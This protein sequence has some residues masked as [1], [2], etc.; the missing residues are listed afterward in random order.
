MREA[1][2]ESLHFD[3]FVFHNA[4]RNT[5]KH[6]ILHTLSKWSRFDSKCSNK[7]MC[8]V[9]RRARREH[10]PWIF[11]TPLDPQPDVNDIIQIHKYYTVLKRQSN[12]KRRISWITAETSQSLGNVALVEY[13]GVLETTE[14]SHGNAKNSEEMYRRTDPKV[15]ELAVEKLKIKKP[16]QVYQEMV[17]EDSIIAPKNFQ[18]LRDIKYREKVKSGV[19]HGNNIADDLLRVMDMLTSNAYV[20]KVEQ[21]KNR[22]PTVFLYHD[23]Q[24]LDMVHFLKNA[25]EPRVGIDRTFNLGPFFATTFVYKNQK[26]VRKE[27]QE[28]PIFLGPVMLHKEADYTVYHSF[29]SHIR[30]RLAVGITDIDVRIPKTMEF[31][32]DAEKA[33]TKAIDDCFPNADRKLCTKHLK[34]NLSDYL[35]NRAGVTATERKTIVIKFSAKKELFWQMTVLTLKKNVSLWKIWQLKIHNFL[36]TSKITLSKTYWSM[37]SIQ[38]AKSLG[39]TTTVSQWT[40]FLNWK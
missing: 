26:V 20:Q 7:K 31:G 24:I 10:F 18:Q 17:E 35:K 37:S 5:K 2:F 29:F 14:S 15:M 13:Y 3:H 11:Q 36:I 4:M 32:S 16:R 27:T 23:N 25:Q 12:Y 33:L 19:Q 9:R 40:I 28:H 39:P 34:D 38:K 1:L 8:P 6:S 21:S 30:T 22:V